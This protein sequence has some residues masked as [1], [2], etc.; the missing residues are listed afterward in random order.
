MQYSKFGRVVGRFYFSDI[1]I[2]ALL[3]PETLAC[4]LAYT[5]VCYTSDTTLFFLNCLFLSALLFFKILFLLL[6]TCT[7]K[8]EIFFCFNF[9]KSVPG[10]EKWTLCLPKISSG[11]VY[12]FGWESSGCNLW[13]AIFRFFT[14]SDFRGHKFWKCFFGHVLF[15]MVRK[16][17]G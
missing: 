6:C 1:D 13:P 10:R 5:Y 14:V 11:L 8:W 9:E 12:D 16:F 3:C 15:F 2:F 4:L 7:K 17:W